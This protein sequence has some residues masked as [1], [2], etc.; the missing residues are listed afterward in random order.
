MKGFDRY[1]S[2]LGMFRAIFEAETGRHPIS[3]L[4]YAS[5]ISNKK[6][7]QA[8]NKRTGLCKISCHK[9]LIVALSVAQR[10]QYGT[11][12]PAKISNFVVSPHAKTKSAQNSMRN[13]LR[14]TEI[15]SDNLA[16]RTWYSNR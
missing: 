16:L 11:R 4:P 14:F 1:I 7:V 8:T 12:G 13:I 9:E 6:G 10:E 15:F 2:D 3:N 5:M